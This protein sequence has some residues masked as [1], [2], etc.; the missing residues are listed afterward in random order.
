MASAGAHVADGTG[1]HPAQGVW[2]RGARE[3]GFTLVELMVVLLV[4][5]IL[6]AIAIPTFLGVTTQVHAKGTESDL[7]NAMTVMKAY[8]ASKLSYAGFDAP[9]GNSSEPSLEWVDQSTSVPLSGN[10]N[11]VSVYSATAS[12]QS[13]LVAGAM[14]GQPGCWAILDTSDQ[15]TSTVL[16]T[17]VH[18]PG[19][20][21]W[22]GVFAPSAS[23]PCD[24]AEALSQISGESAP[25][26][27]G[28]R[29]PLSAP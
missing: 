12:G 25:Y 9:A 8:Q 27:W 17:T 3:A 5:G 4:M 2:A 22:Y 16:G 26:T 20:G 21:V 7:V 14:A 15:A 18:S 28:T 29:W 1:A 10:Y 13:E 11:S 19:P 23:H 24:A 6:M